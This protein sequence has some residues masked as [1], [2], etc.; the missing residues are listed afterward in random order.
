[1]KI[2]IL[3][4]YLIGEFL[5]YFIIALLSLA[6]FYVVVDFISNIGAFTKHSP[7]FKYILAYFAYK[8]PEIIYRVLPLAVLLA[9]LLSISFF[10]KNNEIM[11]VKSSGV[12][13]FKF[14]APLI[15][16]GAVISLSAFLLSNF[17]AVRSNVLRRVI[18]EKYINKND[19]YNISSV[20]R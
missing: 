4:K 1:M 11:A 20:Y 13:M 2:K 6:A 18:M 12:G 14:F 10:N 7:E 9:A 5:K 17:V 19:S 15:V 3:Q 8:T 16:L